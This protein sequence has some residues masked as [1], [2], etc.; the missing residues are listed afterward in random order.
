MVEAF[1]Y[2]IVLVEWLLMKPCCVEICGMLC[3]GV[4]SSPLFLLLVTERSEMGL[5]NVPMFLSLFGFGFGMKLLVS[6]CEG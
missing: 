1:C 3:M 4:V 5:Y 6:M 2:G